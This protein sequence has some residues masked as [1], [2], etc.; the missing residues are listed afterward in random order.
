MATPTKVCVF[1]PTSNLVDILNA[2][3]GVLFPSQGAASAGY[4]V[5]LN[6]D[7]LIDASLTGQGVTP[8]VAGENIAAGDLVHLYIAGSPGTL[9]M[10]RASAQASGIAPDGGTYPKSAQGVVRDAV[11]AG[12]YATV[13]FEGTFTYTDTLSEFSVSSIGL[14]VYLADG[15]SGG[16]DP[17]DITL[18][19]PSGVG[20]IYE[21]VGYVINF[22]SPNSVAVMF[23]APFAGK[24][25]LPAVTVYTDQAN[26]YGAFLQKFQAGSNF[27][28]VDP[29]DTTKVL[30]FNVSAIGAGTTRTVSVPNAASNTIQPLGS[31]TAHEWI[32][33]VDSSGVQHLSQPAASDLSNGTTGSGLVVLQTGPTLITPNIGAATGTSLVLTGATP[34]VSGG[35]IGFGVTTGFGTGSSGVGVTTTSPGSPPSG[36]TQPQ[37][38]AGYIEINVGGLTAWIPYMF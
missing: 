15:T 21:A 34:A 1:N 8:A 14:P 18:T 38:I 13:D 7:G 28:L 11:S 16:H 19:R 22:V 12:N 3:D 26:T 27:D 2:V 35:Q 37:V 6:P 33:Y 25:Q 23:I 31:A 10:E 20:T 5:V 17:G 9:T 36:P 24:F 29:T 32:Q 30:Q 4:P